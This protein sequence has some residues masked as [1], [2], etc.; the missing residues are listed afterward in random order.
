MCPYV[1]YFKGTEHKDIDVF[2]EDKVIVATCF[3][4]TATHIYI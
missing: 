4:S 3:L 1:Y 2:S